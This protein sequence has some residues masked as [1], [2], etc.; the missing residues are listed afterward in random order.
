MKNLLTNNNTTCYHK[1]NKKEGNKPVLFGNYFERGG[2]Y[3][4][5]S[6]ERSIPQAI[7]YSVRCRLSFVIDCLASVYF[8]RHRI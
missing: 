1:I 3:A 4:S 6:N 2:F 5:D 8:P 7:F